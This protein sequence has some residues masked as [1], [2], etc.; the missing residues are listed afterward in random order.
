MK[1]IVERRISFSVNN[2]QWKPT[3]LW[4][5]IQYMEAEQAKDWETREL[6]WEEIIN[7]VDLVLNASVSERGLFYKRKVLVLPDIAN[8]GQITY[9]E[10]DFKNIKIRETYSRPKNLTIRELQELLPAE[11]FIEY[12]HDRG[13]KYFA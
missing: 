9:T 8:F 3:S 7:N 2:G 10:K 13:I 11:T 12:L 1:E 6:T 5:D 4:R